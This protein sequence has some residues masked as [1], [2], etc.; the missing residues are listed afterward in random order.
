MAG[1]SQRPVQQQ[2]LHW[3]LDVV[4]LCSQ[5]SLASTCHTRSC[6]SDLGSFY[7]KECCCLTFTYLEKAAKN[8]AD[9]SPQKAKVSAGRFLAF[10]PST[11][12]TSQSLQG[13]GHGRASAKESQQKLG[14]VSIWVW[15]CFLWTGDTARAIKPSTDPFQHTPPCPP[16]PEKLAYGQHGCEM[17]SLCHW[18][19]I[20]TPGLVGAMP[21]LCGPTVKWTVMGWGAGAQRV[22]AGSLLHLAF[23]QQIC[24]CQVTQPAIVK[25]VNFPSEYF[26]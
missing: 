13:S 7:L 25:T 2:E 4:I 18:R 16:S 12:V 8:R 24:L 23:Y 22:M 6:N 11:H 14:S 20:S 9:C 17:P 10:S 5:A 21:V 26:N 3:R 19:N 15:N 1:T